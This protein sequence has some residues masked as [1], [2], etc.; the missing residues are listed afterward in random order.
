M[1]IPSK[2]KN[3]KSEGHDKISTSFLKQIGNPLATPL[4][5]LINKSILEGF[6]DAMKIAI[7]VPISTAKERNELSNY[8][9]VSILTFFFQK[10]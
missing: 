8:R 3:K 7:V 4:S 10:Y 5:I 2:V 1:N 6:P 9:P